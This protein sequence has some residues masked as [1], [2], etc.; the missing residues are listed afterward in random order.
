[1]ILPKL[2]QL[3]LKINKIIFI[4]GET[5]F[6]PPQKKVYFQMETKGIKGI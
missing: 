5:T 6:G 4:D 3:L 2:G 1:L